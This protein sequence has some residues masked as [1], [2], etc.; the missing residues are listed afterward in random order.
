MKLL[1]LYIAMEIYMLTGKVLMGMDEETQGK[2]GSQGGNA[3]LL[4][5]ASQEGRARDCRSWE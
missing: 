4:G 2:K 5:A 1:K 3:G